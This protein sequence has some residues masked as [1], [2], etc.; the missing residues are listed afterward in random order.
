MAIISFPNIVF[1]LEITLDGDYFIFKCRLH[2]K[3]TLDGVTPGV[4]LD[5]FSIFHTPARILFLA[6]AACLCG[7]SYSCRLQAVAFKPKP[8]HC[9]TKYNNNNQAEPSPKLAFQAVGRAVVRPSV[10]FG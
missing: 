4:G 2:T 10:R 7:V 1:T 9:L 6:A 5:Y 8:S 3:I